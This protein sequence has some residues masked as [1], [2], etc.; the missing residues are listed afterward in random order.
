MRI[1][2][3]DRLE[4]LYFLTE[5]WGQAV[6]SFWEWFNLGVDEGVGRGRQNGLNEAK[7]Y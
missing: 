1:G 5:F 7:R 2:E 4:G 3:R 6:D